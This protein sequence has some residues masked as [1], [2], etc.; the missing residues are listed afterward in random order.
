MFIQEFD[1]IGAHIIPYSECKNFDITN[2]LL[3]GASLHTLYDTHKL[4]INPDTLK[5]EISNDLL[6]TS[7]S[8]F[9][10]KQIIL[11]DKYKNKIVKQNVKFYLI[12]SVKNL[13][14][15]YLRYCKKN[16]KQMNNNSNSGS[17]LEEKTQRK[18]L[19]NSDTASKV[20]S[21]SN[22]SNDSLSEEDAKPQ[23]S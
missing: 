1:L 7:A 18:L 2:G 12:A 9:K 17:E 20:N 22:E 16:N 19:K 21:S 5:I 11:P 13:E 6:K 15:M 10:D 23:E 14:I 4:T 8:K 3:L